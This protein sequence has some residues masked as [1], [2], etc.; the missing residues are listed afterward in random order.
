MSVLSKIDPKFPGTESENRWAFFCP[1]C[2]CAHW[3]WTGENQWTW[4][5]SIDKPTVRPSILTKWNTRLFDPEGIN[6]IDVICHS[7]ITDG[8]I[9]FLPDC[10]H[11]LAGQTVDLED[12][13]KI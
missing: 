12:W 10:T 8:K 1:G 9:Q 4:N 6:G 11:K 5:G 7:F 2:N 13:D 3:F